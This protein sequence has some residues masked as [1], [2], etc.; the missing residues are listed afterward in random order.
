MTRG[1][2]NEPALA[3]DLNAWGPTMRQCVSHVVLVAQLV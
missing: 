1:A 2:R 3:D